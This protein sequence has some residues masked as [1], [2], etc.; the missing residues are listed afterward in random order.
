MKDKIIAWYGKPHTKSIPS[1]ESDG[2]ANGFGVFDLV[3]LNW[4]WT[5]DF[6]DLLVEQET[7]DNGGKDSNL[8]CAGGSQISGDTTN[9]SAFMRL[10]FRSSLKASFT[11][12][13][14][15]FRCAKEVP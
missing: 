2:P 11:T 5:Q 15:G 10:S 7:R 6:N 9:Y 4:E 3:G 8:F 1:V 12:A 13:D 14:L